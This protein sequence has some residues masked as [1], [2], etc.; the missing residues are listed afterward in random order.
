M[1]VCIFRTVRRLLRAFSVPL[2]LLR[3]L[4]RALERGLLQTA[5]GRCCQSL[6]QNVASGWRCGVLPDMTTV[7]CAEC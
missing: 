3:V 5:E 1:S 4:S 6:L 2:R 7:S